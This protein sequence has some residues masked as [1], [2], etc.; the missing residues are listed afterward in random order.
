MED[1]DAERQ[2]VAKGFHRR[3]RALGLGGTVVTLVGLVLVLITGF[4][5]WLQ[6]WAARIDPNP[7]AVVALYFLMGNAISQ[8]IA[9]P[10]GLASHR[11]EGAYGLSN[12]G[13]GSWARDVAK[14]LLLSFGFGLASVEVL[15]WSL[16][17]LGPWWWP[18][19]WALGL[20]V[21]IVMGFIAPVLL[22]PLFHRYEA[23]GEGEVK[24]R[25]ERL[26]QRVGLGSMGIYRMEASP[27]TSRGMAALVGLG[28][29]RRVILSDTLLQAYSPEET[30]AVFAHEL[31]HHAHWDTARGFLLGSLEGLLALAVVDL[32][33][34]TIGPPLD[35][36]NPANVASLPLIVLIFTLLGFLLG[37][38]GNYLSRRR[39]ASAD[40][41][42]LALMANP[43]A[44]A[45]AMVKI[46]DQNLSDAHPHPLV[47]ALFYSHPAGHR[48]VAMARQGRGHPGP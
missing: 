43:E 33:L 29:T 3:A 25:L 48:R 18:T 34:R 35:L 2:R 13:W 23:L 37:P 12:Q 46:H 26:S 36:P 4:S 11:L 45:S 9:I 16:R 6:A 5:L 47:E 39:E 40:R 32:G 19:M 28:R 27:K 1:F 42:A 44:F 21:S 31:G 14:G 15:Y 38:M 41:F 10:L 30:E 24:E 7:W 17:N 8:G 20:A 22:M